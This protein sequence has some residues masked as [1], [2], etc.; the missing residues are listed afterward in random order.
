VVTTGS[1]KIMMAAMMPKATFWAT[2]TGASAFWAAARTGSLGHLLDLG[3]GPG[4]VGLEVRH[5]LHPLTQAGL[6]VDEVGDAGSEYSNSGLQ[7][8]ASNGQTSTQ[9]PQYMQSA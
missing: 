9:M 6:V 3:L 1:P 4:L 5:G 7:K 8:M 2:S